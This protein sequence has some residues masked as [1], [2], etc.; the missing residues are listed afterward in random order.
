MS[1]PRRDENDR[2]VSGRERTTFA[3][4]IA[5]TALLL[6]IAGAAGVAGCQLLLSDDTTA[7]CSTNGDCAARGFLF[8][9]CGPNNTCVNPP[10]LCTKKEECIPPPGSTGDCVANKCV[11][12]P[13]PPSD[14][15]N[16]GD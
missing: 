5:R 12:T 7:Q 2:P 14:F 16:T 1:D 13:I 11:Y 9:T 4:R 8:A 6:A 15:C 10:D 3:A